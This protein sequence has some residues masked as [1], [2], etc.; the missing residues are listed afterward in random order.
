KQVLKRTGES[1]PVIKSIHPDIVV[2]I[3]WAQWA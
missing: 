1:C 2:T 3:D